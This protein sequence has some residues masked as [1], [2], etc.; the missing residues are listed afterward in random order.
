MTSQDEKRTDYGIIKIH[1][2]VIAQVA[3]LAA[4]E[5]EGVNRISTSLFT[6]IL[7]IISRA[8][9]GARSVPRIL[10]TFAGIM[11]MDNNFMWYM[12]MVLICITAMAAFDNISKAYIETHKSIPTRC[13]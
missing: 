11:I 8:L 4:R 9:I 12:G 5:V 10:E 6:E 3:S 7:R 1:K 13:P 2:N